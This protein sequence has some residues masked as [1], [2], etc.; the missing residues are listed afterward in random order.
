MII[1]FEQDKMTVTHP[2]GH[3][4]IYTTEQVEA[5]KAMEQVMLAD[6]GMHIMGIDNMLTEMTG[7][8]PIS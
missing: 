8:L 1:E 2:S 4:D 7:V 3:V 5:F 6:I